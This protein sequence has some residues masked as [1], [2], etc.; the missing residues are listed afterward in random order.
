MLRLI[1]VKL[2]ERSIKLYNIISTNSC[3]NLIRFLDLQL[4][5]ISSSLIILSDFY[6]WND[7][8]FYVN[9]TSYEN[10]KCP[11][12]RTFSTDNDKCISE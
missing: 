3:K 7:L 2:F 4:H 6:S 11:L 10:S 1:T 9:P 8:R 5:F 12:Y